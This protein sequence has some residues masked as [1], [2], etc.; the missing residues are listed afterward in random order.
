MAAPQIS[1]LPPPPSP[2]D[3]PS[4]F[5]ERADDFLGALPQFQ[6][7]A[8]AQA[9]HT[10]ERAAEADQSAT[11]AADSATAAASSAAQAGNHSA[12]ASQWA[13]AAEDEQV[14]AGQYSARHHAAKAQASAG[15]AA[16]SAA[17]ASMGREATAADHAAVNQALL[18]LSGALPVYAA[19]HADAK[20]LAFGLASGTPIIIG[21]DERYSGRR[22]L[23]RANAAGGA[24]L[25]LDFV[26]GIYQREDLVEFVGYVQMQLL[27]VPAT[28]AAPGFFGA[29]AADSNYLY[30]AT[31]ANTWKRVALE[32]F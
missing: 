17:A 2:A 7:Q 20:L 10:D 21:A 27:D 16:S 8:N 23:N 31:G 12:K 6:A 3:S 19:T 29:F 25:V 1:P 30:V 18:D 4:T 13:A 22:T 24:S 11:A 5:T 28:S 15:A 32:A 26:N 9:A 14:E